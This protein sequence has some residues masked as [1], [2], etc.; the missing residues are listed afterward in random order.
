MKT[1]ISL[2]SELDLEGSGGSDNRLFSSFFLRRVLRRV[3]ITFLSDF[4]RFCASF[5][6]PLG[7]FGVPLASL[8]EEILRL[9][10]GSGSGGAQGEPRGS[11]L[12][13]FWELF[14]GFVD[15]FWSYV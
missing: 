8:W 9:F 4:L 6:L 5:G 3:R 14:G 2:E 12:E 15:R 11:F 10:S 13:P 1:V 7:P